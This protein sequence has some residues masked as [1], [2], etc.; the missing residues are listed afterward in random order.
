VQRM[1]RVA[2]A[3]GGSPFRSLRSRAALLAL[4]LIALQPA[5]QAR[6]S[7]FNWAFGSSGTTNTTV[8]WNPVGIPGANDDTRYWQ[9]ATYGV[10]VVAPAD[11]ASTVSMSNGGNP[12]FVAGTLRIRNSFSVDG[13]SA[14]SITGGFVR[15][16]WLAI[17]P[18]SLTISG[19]TTQARTT[20]PGGTDYVGTASGFSSAL[21]VNGGALFQSTALVVPEYQSA[22]GTITVAGHPLNSP[23]STLRV[24]FPGT[25]SSYQGDLVVGLQGTGDVEL[26][27]GGLIH[28]DGDLLI[29]T[30]GVGTVH[31]FHT[32]SFLN[33]PNPILDVY[34]YAYISQNTPVAAAP[35]TQPGGNGV[36]ELDSGYASLWGMFIGDPDGGTGTLKLTGGTMVIEDGLVMSIA[37]NGHLDLRGGVLRVTGRDDP[38]FFNDFPLVLRQATPIAISS[39]VGSPV[40]ALEGGST[41]EITSASATALVLGRGGAGTLH[42]ANSTVTIR[43]AVIVADSLSGTGTLQADSSSGFNVTG[44]MTVG[45]GNGSISLRG[46]S[47]AN[48]YAEADFTASGTTG[49]ALTV[50]NQSGAQFQGLAIGGT[51]SAATPGNVVAT[52]DT[53]STLADG[54]ATTRV[55]KNAGHLLVRNSSIVA[56]NVLS[57]SGEV[58]LS[59]GTLTGTTLNLLDTGNLHGVGTAAGAVSLDPTAVLAI[60]ASDPPGGALIVGDST[61]TN[62]F[63][64]S[65]LT[66][67]E[68]DTMVLLCKGGAPLGHVQ[69]AGGMLRLPNGGHVRVGDLLE[70]WGRIE[71]DVLD[72]GTVAANGGAPTMDLAGHLTCLGGAITGTSLNVLPAGR[73]SARGSIAGS[74]RLGGALDMGPAPALLTLQG[75]TTILSTNAI[76]M[77]VGSR[78]SHLQDSLA[79]GQSV[80]LAGVLDLRTIQANP[81]AAGDTLFLITAPSITGT[82]SSVTL[83]GGVANSFVQAVYQPGRVIV[84]VLKNT[85]GVDP[86]VPPPAP[87]ALSFA[88]LGD[89]RNEVLALDLPAPASVRAELFDVTGRRVM[90]LERGVVEAGRH[91]YALESSL[92]SGLY[93]ARAE[94][95]DSHGPH[96]LIA[97]C[98]RLK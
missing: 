10:T 5:T 41:N 6:G 56:V 70:G 7:I 69:L 79:F 94:I 32:G 39:S 34:G 14:T 96:V 3:L 93:F 92:E 44:A 27:N 28:T 18:G 25:Y 90:T 1:I 38:F 62:G 52:I 31:E 24:V 78:A 49:S 71:G 15:A 84:V 16:G 74:I 50:T 35:N 85:A 87:Q 19:G 72:D 61:I 9:N 21:T 26:S 13:L 83:N 53:G 55:W 42:L 65:G 51:A 8:N 97:R 76:T 81:P 37:N 88:A 30:N 66:R 98:V 63:L 95:T 48:L 67:V 2:R 91:R 75:A 20:Y 45:P 43:G 86:G 54:G 89:P 47:G 4:V 57:C 17:G 40:L 64:S 80:S 33:N 73:V 60:L 46:G 68:Q 11:T 23:A 36:M 59:H 29:G 82:F 22:T 58:D 77:R 12:K